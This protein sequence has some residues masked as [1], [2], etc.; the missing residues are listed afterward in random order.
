[1][2]K[3]KQF[4]SDNKDK[5]KSIYRICEWLSDI[6]MLMIFNP[7]GSKQEQDRIARLIAQ[8]GTTNGLDY[9]KL[10]RLFGAKAEQD[11]VMEFLNN[12]RGL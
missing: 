6:R 10:S 3:F 2:S 12:M 1:M 4:V 5:I 11:H 9:K 8:E 7:R